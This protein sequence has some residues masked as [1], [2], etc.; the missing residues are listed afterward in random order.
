MTRRSSIFGLLLLCAG[1][2][3]I[4]TLAGAQ[5]PNS[6]RDF[7]LSAGDRV[8]VG[9]WPDSSLGGVFPI[10]ESGLVHLPLLGARQASGKT[11]SVFREELREGY[12][13]DLQLPAVS[14]Q[15]QF[16]VGII[17]AVRAPGVYWVDPSYGVFEVLSEA[18]G[19]LDNAAEDKI[20]VT[21]ASGESYRIDAA[22]LHEPGS[23]EA[24]LA[25]RSGDRVVVPE[26]GGWNWGI[27]LQSL[28]LVVTILSVATR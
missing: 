27:F 6:A 22:R 2:I 28:T 11:V 1:L 19:F 21:R 3:G 26:G 12:A 23:A 14:V 18:G 7:V 25:L 24:L 5:S 9:V 8:V 4:P 15:A 17:G 20:V 10:E 13:Q 16:R